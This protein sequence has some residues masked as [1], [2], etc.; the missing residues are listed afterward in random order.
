MDAKLIT[1]N[2][3]SVQVR[4]AR[5]KSDT[6]PYWSAPLGLAG[7]WLGKHEHHTYIGRTRADAAYRL[8]M[9]GFEDLVKDWRLY[10]GA[11]YQGSP[12]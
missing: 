10:T 2:E 5:R 6:W 7:Y 1:E 8:E 9:Y 12:G 3:F 11:N 4:Y